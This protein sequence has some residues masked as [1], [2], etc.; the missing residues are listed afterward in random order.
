M[1]E[2][3]DWGKYNE[4][5]AARALIQDMGFVVLT[6]SEYEGISFANQEI[7]NL[8]E[9]IDASTKLNLQL[10]SALSLALNPT[11]PSD[12]LLAE[13]A[14]AVAREALELEVEDHSEDVSSSDIYGPGGYEDRGAR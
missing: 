11:I 5:Q 4:F 14:L 2:A 12:Y 3:I 13:K 1:S 8:R 6:K 9:G 7:S 10:M